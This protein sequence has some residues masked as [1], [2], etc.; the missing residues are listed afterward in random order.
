MQILK[1]TLEQWRVLQAI[2]E[3]GGYAQAAE[4][5]H[6][7]QS[8]VSYMVARLQEQLGVPLLTIEGRKARLTESGKALLVQASDLL[9]DAARLEQRAARL[10]QGWEAQVRP[11]GDAR[12]EERRVGEEWVRTGGS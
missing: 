11:V 6:R 9:D 4:A 2:V 7:S 1:T 8:S 5:L 10:E 12:S 3:H